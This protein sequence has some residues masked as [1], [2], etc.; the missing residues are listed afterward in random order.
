VT[1]VHAKAVPIVKIWDPELNLACDLNVN[2]QVAV[3]NTKLVKTY[4]ELDDRVRPLAMIVKHWT[5]KRVINE[6]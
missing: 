1:C 6:G 2:N 4:I 5:K 3:K